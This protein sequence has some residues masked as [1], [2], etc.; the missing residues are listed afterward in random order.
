MVS[1]AIQLLR[2]VITCLIESQAEP[3]IP[4]LQIILNFVI[5]IH[6]MLNVITKFVHFLLL[7]VVTVILVACRR[8]TQSSRGRTT[9]DNRS[10]STTLRNQLCNPLI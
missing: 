9:N 8:Q 5:S 1:F 6:E 2:V 3:P 7:A 10:L 4:S